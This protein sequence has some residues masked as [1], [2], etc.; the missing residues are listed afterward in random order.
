[1]NVI[2]DNQIVYYYKGKNKIKTKEK[3][4]SKIKAIF[5]LFKTHSLSCHKTN[6]IA[7]NTRWE[8]SEAEHKIK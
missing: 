1:M 6:F 4:H 3:K 2:S 8:L 7:G 5:K